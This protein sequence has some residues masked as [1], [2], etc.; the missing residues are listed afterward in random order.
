MATTVLV[1]DDSASVRRMIESALRFKGYAVVTAVDGLEALEVLE[2]GMPL[3]ATSAEA[4]G[5]PFGLV[6][7]DINMPRMDGLSVLKAIRERA[8]CANLPVLMLTTEGQDSD[9]ERALALGATDYIVKPFK[10]NEFLSRVAA[11]L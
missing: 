7:L 10:P 8:E 9:R 3:D 5:E 2:H 11:L 4:A 1:V 6:V